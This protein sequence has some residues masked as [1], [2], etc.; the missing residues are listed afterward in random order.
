M[1]EK[2]V[3]ITPFFSI[4]IFCIKIT[5]AYDKELKLS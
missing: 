1:L 2:N 4:N 5:D 3:A